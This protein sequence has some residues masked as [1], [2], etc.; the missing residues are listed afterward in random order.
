MRYQR[1]QLNIDQ[2]DVLGPIL[3]EVSTATPL[4]KHLDTLRADVYS[5]PEYT[6]GTYRLDW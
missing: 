6:N 2:G 1:G 4:S 5:R 3:R